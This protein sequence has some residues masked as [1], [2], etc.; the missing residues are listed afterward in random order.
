VIIGARLG[1]TSH[2]EDN[3]R[4]FELKLESDDVRKIEEV[5][6]KSNDLFEKIGD[7]G[8]EYR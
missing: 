5:C 1:I 6:S 7:C 4:V 3:S 8:D 2:L